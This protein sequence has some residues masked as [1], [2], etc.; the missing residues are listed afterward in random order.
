MTTLVSK[1]KE[2]TEL[3]NNNEFALALLAG[4]GGVAKYLH[5]FVNGATFKLSVLLAN[6]FISGFSGLMFAH[7]GRAYGLSQELLY[8]CA[9]VGGAA[10][11]QAI[12]QAIEVIK[13]K[14][15]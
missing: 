5:Q 12:E 2:A 11:W 3:V 15:K 8:V 14:L 7:M 1:L 9:G 10:G 6:V 13:G 4:M